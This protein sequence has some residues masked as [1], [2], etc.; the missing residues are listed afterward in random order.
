MNSAYTQSDKSR[1]MVCMSVNSCTF[2]QA[3][4]FCF[5]WLC[6]T[7]VRQSNTMKLVLQ[8]VTLSAIAP[9]LWPLWSMQIRS[10]MELIPTPQINRRPWKGFVEWARG[11]SPLASRWRPVGS[12]QA[13]RESTSAGFCLVLTYSY[14]NEREP[15]MMLHAAQGP[16]VCAVAGQRVC[17]R[18]FETEVS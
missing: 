15:V 14:L 18:T 9:T 1:V 17:T 10:T 12:F 11:H 5:G 4:L 2:N 7:C 16:R 13:S 8:G 3:N 6:A